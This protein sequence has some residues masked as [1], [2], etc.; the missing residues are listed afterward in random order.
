MIAQVLLIASY[1]TRHNNEPHA[2]DTASQ[3]TVVTG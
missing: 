3:H 1:A 2:L